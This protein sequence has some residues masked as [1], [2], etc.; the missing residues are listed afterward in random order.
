M[1][2]ILL[3]YPYFKPRYDRSSFRFPPLGLGYLASSLKICGYQPHLLDCTFLD[4]DEAWQRAKQSKAD[5]VGIYSMVSMQEDSLTFARLMRNRCDLLVAG[6]PLPSCS[7]ATFLDDF[8]LVVVGEGEQTIQEIVKAYDAGSEYSSIKGLQYRNQGDTIRTPTRELQTDLDGIPFPARDLFQNQKYIDHWNKRRGYSATTV[9]TTRGCP[10]SCEFCSNAVFGVSYRERSSDNVLSEV[11]QALALGYDRIH[12]ADDVFTLN[13]K[14]MMQICEEILA[15][16]MEFKW[17]CLARVDSID[18]ATAD[19]MKKAGCDRIFFGIESGD[20]SIL[21]L[22]N[23]RILLDQARRAVETARAAGLKTGAFFI[24]CYPGETDETV[25]KT[26]RFATSLP[27]DYLSFT[28]PYP[29]PG[30]RLSER[31]KSKVINEWKGQSS[32][33]S[34]H[35]LIFESEFSGAKMRFAILKGQIQFAFQKRSKSPVSL[36]KKPFEKVTDILFKI[37]K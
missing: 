20:E 22:M 32:F 33:L 21:M 2:Q 17:E 9:I 19:A 4:R 34:D 29:L 35:S 13:K 37:M 6:G 30:T 7:P 18:R 3:I 16:G 26:I 14:R 23:K 36:A 10:F 12:F 5:I 15:R 1:T 27:L 25:L 28:M 31:I 11:E 8:D 24:L